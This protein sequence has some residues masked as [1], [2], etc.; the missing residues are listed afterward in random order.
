M[1]LWIDLETTGLS[2]TQDVPIEVGMI[3][4]EEKDLKEIAR[5]SWLIRMPGYNYVPT[6]EFVKNMHIENGLLRELHKAGDFTASMHDERMVAWLRMVCPNVDEIEL[7][8][9]GSSV[10]FD[11]RFIE[12]WF[13]ELYSLLH[14]RHFDVSS[15]KMLSMI[16]GEE[17]DKGPV[18]PHR[19]L[20]DLDNDIQWIKD[21]YK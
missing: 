3:L 9:A 20:G 21:N 14:H 5:C 18:D 4:T 7:H 10:H 16:K 8:P 12:Q 17:Y 11:V 6:V 1:L 13:P 15:I 19:A 2:F